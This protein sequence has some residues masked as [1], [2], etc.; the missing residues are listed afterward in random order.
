MMQ[1]RM[2][3]ARKVPGKGKRESVQGHLIRWE[4]SKWEVMYREYSKVCKVSKSV[5]PIDL[6]YSYRS[7]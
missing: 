3:F 2:I 1:V 7:T 6:F 4:E 5:Y